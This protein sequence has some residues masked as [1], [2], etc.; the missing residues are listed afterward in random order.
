MG[1]EEIQQKGTPKGKSGGDQNIMSGKVSSGGISFQG[2]RGNVISIHQYNGPDAKELTALFEKLYQHIESR[3]PDPNV[4]K[5]E[6]V[7]TV[8]KIEQ[9]TSK[10]EQANETKLT[11]WMDNLNKIAPDVIDVA[12][13]SLGGPVSGVTAVLKKIADRARQAPQP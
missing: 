7:E 11:R 6:I 3:P 2:G 8:Q 4:D 12:L 5:E 1:E 13:A 9:E 10:G